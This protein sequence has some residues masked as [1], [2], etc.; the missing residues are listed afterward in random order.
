MKKILIFSVYTLFSVALYGQTYLLNSKGTYSSSSI[1]GYVRD[2]SFYNDTCYLVSG[3]GK[4][5]L[6]TKNNGSV[7]AT[8]NFSSITFNEAIKIYVDDD[9]VLVLDLDYLRGYTKKGVLKYSIP[10]ASADAWCRYFWVKN[11]QEIMLV[12]N[13]KI[14][15]YNYSTRALLKSFT[16]SYEFTSNTNNGDRFVNDGNKL[17]DWGIKLVTYEYRG[18]TIYESNITTSK[19][20]SLT[21][22]ENYLACF[23][24]NETLWF[25][26]FDRSKAF[27]VNSVFSG[28]VRNCG[29]F[30]PSSKN[31]TDDDLYIESGN[32][33][34]K[35]FYSQGKTYVINAPLNKVEFY[36]LEK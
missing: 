15:V 26:Y 4:K 11:K 2:A 6:I 18:G 20:R 16:P 33:F 12:F 27:F 35:V 25:N 22:E 31:P 13:N 7:V 5:I 8:N 29:N 28:V 34:L 30:L 19:Y 14:V 3:D 32:P 21:S 17:Y 23:V 10:V 1:N 9:H 36:M 24:G